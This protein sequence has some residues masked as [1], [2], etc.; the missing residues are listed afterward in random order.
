MRVKT[1]RR[2]LSIV[3]MLAAAATA[4]AATAEREAAP[5][6][7]APEQLSPAASV[8]ELRMSEFYKLPV[9][10]YGLEPTA[11]LLGLK[12][13]RVRVR[14]YVVQ[15]EEPS[16]GL[17]L[18]TP[19][20]TSLAELADG[21]ADYLP[22]ATLFVHLPE[23]LRDKVVAFQPGIW[24]VVGRLDVGGRAEANERTS[25]VRL[26]L[27]DLDSA[28]SPGGRP[29]ALGERREGHDAHRH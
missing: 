22:P 4:R 23:P 5:A 20:P 18:L 26:S 11:R 25:Y 10:P 28:R 29:P 9:G 24:E 27:D 14:G 12:G 2:L 6:S 16:P 3:T 15:E 7:G 17:F 21:P 1:T 13:Q 19:T 8:A